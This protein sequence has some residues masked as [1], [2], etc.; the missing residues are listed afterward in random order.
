MRLL[1]TVCLALFTFDSSAATLAPHPGPHRP[2]AL[3]MNEG[4]QSGGVK[5]HLKDKTALL[6]APIKALQMAPPRLQPLEK[7]V[8]APVTKTHSDP[9]TLNF[10]HVVV[11]SFVTSYDQSVSTEVRKV[12]IG[13]TIFTFLSSFALLL[14]AGHRSTKRTVT[15]YRREEFATVG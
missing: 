10:K 9:M 6:V 15:K 7:L 11:P 2:L 8:L 3:D 4:M 12:P 13:S 14:C 5:A 1:L